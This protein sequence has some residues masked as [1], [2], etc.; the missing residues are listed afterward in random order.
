MRAMKNPHPAGS[1]KPA[2]EAQPARRGLVWG[3][4]L[5]V[6]I[7]VILPF[8]LKYFS[9]S[10]KPASAPVAVHTPVADAPAPAKHSPLVAVPAA[11]QPATPAPVAAAVIPVSPAL[12]TTSQLVDELAKIGNG[13]VTPEQAARF[14]A[15]LQELIHRGAASVPAIQQLLQ[16][17][18]DIAYGDVPGGDQLGYS[19]LRATMIDAL[20]QIG[21]PEAQAA[22]LATMNA[23][24]NPSELLQLAQ[25]LNKQAPGQYNSQIAA[26]AQQ[27]LALAQSGQLGTNTELGP[28]FRALQN[29]GGANSTA[30]AAKNDPVDFYN[31]VQLAN[32]PNGQGLAALEQMQQSSSGQSQFIATEMIAQMAGQNG[33]ALDA[34]TQMAQ[35]GQIPQEDWVNLAPIL[36]GQQYQVDSSGQNYTVGGNNLTPD[37]AAQRIALIDSIINSVPPGTGSAKALA[38]EVGVLSAQLNN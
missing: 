24:A 38:Q 2:G 6:L 12:L 3:V 18:T 8:V 26:Q 30:D 17:N 10:H 28:A 15:D 19:S 23:T 33:D 31:A 11:P 22:M 32:Q 1:P 5:I 37:Q 21:G 14:K 16:Q 35:N 4:I 20:S 36:G 27:T 34:F 25:D 7:T 13:P 29:F 9:R